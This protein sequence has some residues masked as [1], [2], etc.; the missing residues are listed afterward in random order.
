[1]GQPSSIISSPLLALEISQQGFGM[2]VKYLMAAMLAIFAITMALQFAG[3]FLQG[4][5][6]YYELPGER[7]S[8]SESASHAP[9]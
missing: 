4:V 7:K 8:E 3:Y 9:A 2:F 5:A 1:M 6:D